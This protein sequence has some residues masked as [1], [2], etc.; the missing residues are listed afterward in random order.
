MRKIFFTIL[1][2][3]ISTSIGYALSSDEDI[4][5]GVFEFAGVND[6]FNTNNASGLKDIS[7]DELPFNNLYLYMYKNI[8]EA[9]TNA[10][11]D[12]LTTI[13]SYGKEDLEKIIFDGDLKIIKDTISPDGPASIEQISQEFNYINDKYQDELEFQIENRRLLY[14]SLANE[15]FMNGDLSDSAGVDLI[16]DLN[17]INKLIFGED[18]EQPDRGG[19]EE[20]VL[21][22]EELFGPVLS[23]VKRESDEEENNAEEAELMICSEDQELADEIA[24]YEENHPEEDSGDSDSGTDDGSDSGDADGSGDSDDSSENGSGSTGSGGTSS[25]EKYSEEAFDEF[26]TEISGNLG[27]WSRELP[28]GEVFCITVKLVSPADDETAEE[29]YE[30]TTNCIACHISYIKQRMDQ[31]TS[32]SLV[33]SRVSTNFL[34]DSTCKEAGGKVTS[35]MHVY[36]IPMPILQDQ[37]D[38]TDENAAKN[39]DELEQNL[40]EVGGLTLPED[41]DQKTPDEMDQERIISTHPV[42]TQEEIIAESLRAAEMRA[43]EIQETFELFELQTQLQNSNDIYEQFS[44]ELAVFAAYFV[45]FQN[46]IRLT[47][48]DAL[49]KLLDKPYCQ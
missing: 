44:A 41:A 9:P 7:N 17:E 5:K 22:S 33:P 10:A 6:N 43:E 16:N 18:L 13:T 28:C 45:N 21:A 20:V 29:K 49:G 38:K 46:Q 39:V 24:E 8:K 36:A 31:T 11:I 2:G 35:S 1:F 37:N 42:S 12:E 14:A 48:N 26:L 34:E 23:K 4:L 27:N 19:S 30:D 25:E 32:E 3:I 47:Y 15:I 40:Y